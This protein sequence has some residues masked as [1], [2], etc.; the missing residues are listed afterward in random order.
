[1]PM[2]R[3]CQTAIVARNVRWQGVVETEPY[4]AGWAQEMIVFLRVLEIEGAVA[5][6]EATVQ[7]SPDGLHWVDEGSRLPLP[8]VVGGLSFVR[9][10]HFGQ[11]VRLRAEIPDDGAC[12]VLVA[13]NSK[14]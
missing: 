8:A 13:I 2:L 7:I 11:Y 10:T 3:E 4:E 14:G 1:M 12:K 5:G 6:I 9:L